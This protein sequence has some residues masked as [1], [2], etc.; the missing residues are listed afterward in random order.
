M[1][2]SLQCVYMY[3]V[4]S[5]PISPHG[6]VGGT[7][8]SVHQLVGGDVDGSLW[9]SDSSACLLAL[10]YKTNNYNGTALEIH[11]TSSTYCYCYYYYYHPSGRE[12]R[13]VQFIVCFSCL[14]ILPQWFPISRFPFKQ[15]KL[16]VNLSHFTF[17][18]WGAYSPVHCIPLSSVANVLLRL[19]YNF[20]SGALF[21]SGGRECS[22]VLCSGAILT[23][24][25]LLPGTVTII[26]QLTAKG[27]RAWATGNLNRIM[28][29]VYVY[30]CFNLCAFFH[31]CLSLSIASNVHRG[32]SHYEWES[33]FSFVK[34]VL[35]HICSRSISMSPCAVGWNSPVSTIETNGQHKTS[36]CQYIYVRSL[37]QL[38][39]I[40]GQQQQR[41]CSSFL[42]FR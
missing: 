27:W 2:T 6:H 8:I 4:S 21:P 1:Y 9:Q 36:I 31:L 33:F 13:F 18:S 38:G 29:S 12:S 35:L 15:L 10:R 39:N 28:I 26:R 7:I 23:T 24:Y 17:T 30:I 3:I 42:C 11:A 37:P 16:L 20:Q 14:Q 5:A 22:S 41:G 19:Q 40:Q 34:L 25:W 32:L